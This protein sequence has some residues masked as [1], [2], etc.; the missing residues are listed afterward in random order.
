MINLGPWSY[1]LVC[2]PGL[3]GYMNINSWKYTWRGMDGSEPFI[4][5]HVH[6]M[7]WDSCAIPF[8]LSSMADWC[9]TKFEDICFAFSSTNCL[10]LKRT[11]LQEK[12]DYRYVQYVVRYDIPMNLLLPPIS[13]FVSYSHLSL[14]PS[15][16]R[17]RLGSSVLDEIF[18]VHINSSRL[19]MVMELWRYLF[20]GFIRISVD[21]HC[22][23]SST[24]FKSHFNGKKVRCEA[25]I[26]WVVSQVTTNNN[27]ALFAQFVVAANKRAKTD[28][29]NSSFYKRNEAKIHDDIS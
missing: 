2:L 15:L 5:L 19:C 4:P 16:S 3:V 7:Y 11:K 8:S 21:R 12:L 26:V 18:F 27:D 24:L 1:A 23:S 14:S 17:Y 13:S 28:D 25:V 29:G 9:E 22:F 10:H 20:I 6:F